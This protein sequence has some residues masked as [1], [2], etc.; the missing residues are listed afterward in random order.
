[1]RFGKIVVVTG[2][3]NTG[4]VQNPTTGYPLGQHFAIATVPFKPYGGSAPLA[5]YCTNA[6][7]GAQVWVEDNS[8]IKKL[9]KT[10][11]TSSGGNI[12]TGI[13]ITTQCVAVFPTKDT[14]DNTLFFQL[15]LGNMN[16]WLVFAYYMQN[17]NSIHIA[18]NYTIELNILYL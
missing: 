2:W 6:E 1:M 5:A 13:P 14:G 4:A 18:S 9:T 10:Y 8:L 7:S 3:V 16:Q 12:M 11:T 15:H 17:D